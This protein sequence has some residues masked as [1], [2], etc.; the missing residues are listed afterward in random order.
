LI[1]IQ[2]GLILKK[3]YLDNC[4]VQRPLD[5]Q[6]QLRIRLEAES[7]ISIIALIDAQEILL[8]ASE[9]SMLEALKTTE[10]NRQEFALGIISKSQQIF[11]ID[12]NTSQRALA[13]NKKGIKTLD[14]LHL[15][16]AEQLQV[17][18]FC[19]CDDN[20]YKKAKKESI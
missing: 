12:A 4:T 6:A 3:L 15:A 17:D 10:S 7:I 11:Q 1:L 8:L 5:N 2:S 19:T 18:Y 14:S 9:I 20:F 16:C 13:L